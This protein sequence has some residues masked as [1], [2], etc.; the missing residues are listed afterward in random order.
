[1][2]IFRANITPVPADDHRATDLPLV[3]E[4]NSARFVHEI[5]NVALEG[6]VHNFN[7]QALSRDSFHDLAVANPN[8]F[9]VDLFLCLGF[10][11]CGERWVLQ[12]VEQGLTER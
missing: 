6:F 4:K 12:R 3:R 10:S 5:V 1:M 11:A 9:L 8:G 2:T 7:G